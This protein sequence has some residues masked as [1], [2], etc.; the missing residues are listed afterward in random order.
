[1]FL[2]G[3]ANHYLP[4]LAM[5]CVFAM[6]PSYL[7][8]RRSYPQYP[9]IAEEVKLY[10]SKGV[11]RKALKAKP[12]TTSTTGAAPRGDK[13]GDRQ[14]VNRVFESFMLRMA[15]LWTGRSHRTG[16]CAPHL[17]SSCTV[18]LPCSHFSGGTSSLLS[19]P[20]S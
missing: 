9:I 11:M 1:M 12:I 16:W 10:Q 17:L 14:R 3:A 19:T 2:T 13:S 18:S 20:V 4:P 7:L 6:L 5:A 8:S 15:V